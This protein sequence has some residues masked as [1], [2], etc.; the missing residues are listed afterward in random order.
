MKEQTYHIYLDSHEKT[1]LLHSLVELKNQLIQ[2]GRYTDC[3]ECLLI[4]P[5]ENNQTTTDFKNESE[6]LTIEK[7]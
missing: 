2:Q 5:Q 1:T 4:L 6:D 7:V 3:V